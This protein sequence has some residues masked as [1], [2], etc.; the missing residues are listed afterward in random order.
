MRAQR[1]DYRAPIAPSRFIVTQRLRN[2]T[3]SSESSAPKNLFRRERRTVARH[4]G[5]LRRRTSLSLPSFC[6]QV[7]CV[8]RSARVGG[9]SSLPALPG[10][11]QPHLSH[12]S[13]FPTGS[14]VVDRAVA[15][16][17]ADDD[18][19]NPWIDYTERVGGY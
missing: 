3:V 15:R 9:L 12:V 16:G 17:G 5:E 11:A 13:F 8:P 14:C 10:L 6:A 18:G 1:V 7:V 2:Q 19:E 4:P